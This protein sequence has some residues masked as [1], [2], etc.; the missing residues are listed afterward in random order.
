MTVIR[1]IK[2]LQNDIEVSIAINI[3]NSEYP[4]QEYDLVK[5][6]YKQLF[7]ILNEPIVLKSK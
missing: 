5:G 1:E 4:S 2:K 3:N 6:F 7:E